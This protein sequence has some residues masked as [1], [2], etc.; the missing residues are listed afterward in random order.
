M[1]M[2]G[3]NLQDKLAELRDRRT[4]PAEILDEVRKVLDEQLAYEDAVLTRLQQAKDEYQNPFLIDELEAHRIFH[5]SHIRELCHIYRLRFLSTK[6]YDRELPVEVLLEIKELERRHQLSLQGFKIMAPAS[7]FR[8]QN[9]DDPMLFAPMG[10]GYYYLVHKWGKDLHPLRKVMMWPL[11]NLENL[12]IF[13]FVISFLLTFVIRELFFWRYQQTSEFIMLY[14]FTFK[15]VAG[16]IVF[17]GIA[18]GKNFSES[19]W[20]SKFFNS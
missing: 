8:L 13:S 1:K 18:L 20:D 3:V 6:Y 14:M 17:Y 5:I 4:K 12:L 16:L 2:K 10:N 9:A 19:I 11:K 7:H 15:S